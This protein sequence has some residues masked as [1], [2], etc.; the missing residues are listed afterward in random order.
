[1]LCSAL[2]SET[3]RRVRWSLAVSSADPWFRRRRNFTPKNA[4]IF[5]TL[6]STR[7][8]IGKLWGKSELGLCHAHFSNT[9]LWYSRPES[10]KNR[11]MTPYIRE[12]QVK[13]KWMKSPVKKE[14]EGGPGML[15]K[16]EPI[17]NCRNAFQRTHPASRSRI[18][19][20]T[21]MI[22]IRFQ[23]QGKLGCGAMP[24]NLL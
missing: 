12:P 20:T 18:Q 6:P 14:S 21:G 2:G 7:A 10:P 13:V 17:K 5:T 11:F 9:S 16:G 19:F 23:N 3:R 4:L 1:M 22:R 8:Q 24:Y 15:S